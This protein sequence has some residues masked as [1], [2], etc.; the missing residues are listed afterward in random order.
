MTLIA[1][2]GYRLCSWRDSIH[3]VPV[4]VT[5]ENLIFFRLHD[6]CSYQNDRI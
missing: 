3:Y 6:K 5:E 4:A 2:G 1:F